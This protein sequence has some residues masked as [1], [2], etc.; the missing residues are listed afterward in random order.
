MFSTRAVA[1]KTAVLHA[2]VY[3]M[4]T[5]VLSPQFGD[6]GLAFEEST[7]DE[8]RVCVYQ[9]ITAATVVQLK[10]RTGW[11]TINFGLVTLV[12]ITEQSPLGHH[13]PE[14]RLWTLPKIAEL[15]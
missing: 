6:V 1:I 4:T 15:A 12:E 10:R 13:E 8:V 9:W 3:D 7:V 14:V 5:Y 11:M 2:I